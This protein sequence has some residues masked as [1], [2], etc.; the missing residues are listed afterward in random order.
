MNFNDKTHEELFEERIAAIFGYNFVHEVRKLP[1]ENE[2]KKQRLADTQVYGV[3][4]QHANTCM[5]CGA[6]LPDDAEF[7]SLHMEKE[8]GVIV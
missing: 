6:C 8:H 4:A 1:N 2:T 7:Q 5:W 3:Q